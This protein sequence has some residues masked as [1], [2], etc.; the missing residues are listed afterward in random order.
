ML[1]L[2][3]FLPDLLPIVFFLLFKNRNKE[4]ELWVVFIY[5]IISF[6]T[7]S[8]FFKF[9]PSKHIEAILFSTFTVIEYTVFA[10]FFY[11]CYRTPALKKW[12][13]IC[14]VVFSASEIL[15]LFL[16]S[17]EKFDALP[18]SM[19]AILIIAF[20]LLFFY[21]QLKTPEST[22]IYSTKKFWVVLAIFVY[23][24]ATFI[25]FISTLYMSEQERRVYW[26]INWVANIIKNVFLAIA[27]IL[28]SEKN[29]KTIQN[30]YN[31]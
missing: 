20:S 9:N 29:F 30:Q 10:I 1:H 3:S 11:L 24:A 17:K 13:I 12:V 14:S 25:L 2:L 21:E 16:A 23:L 26:P 19:E 15:N 27:F 22:F 6:I 7:D 18:A 4:K 31:I 28:K 8:Y 5:S